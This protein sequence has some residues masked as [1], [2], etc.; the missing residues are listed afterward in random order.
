M[1][2]YKV[3]SDKNVKKLQRFRI[4]KL[5]IFWAHP[6]GVL[7]FLLSWYSSQQ[8]FVPC[9]TCGPNFLYLMVFVKIAYCLV[10]FFG[11]A[12]WM[13]HCRSWLTLHVLRPEKGLKF[14]E[15]YIELT[16][17]HFH[18]LS[19]FIVLVVFSCPKFHFFKDFQC[20]I[21]STSW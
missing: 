2:L 5:I 7:H 14:S 19:F 1:E 4:L 6:Q 8:M 9:N 15:K 12:T 16:Y 18:I 11:C 13:V 21:I 17:L 10:F 20:S 3:Q